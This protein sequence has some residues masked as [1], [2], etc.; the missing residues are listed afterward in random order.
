M[1]GTIMSDSL[2]NTQPVKDL[3]RKVSGLDNDSGDARLKRIVHRVVS[4]LFRTI[5]E[6]DVQPDEFWSAMSYLT[7]LGQ[8]NETGLLVPGLGL[9]T[10]LD[11][12]MDGAERKAGIEGGT[13][14]TIE[15]PLYVAGAPFSKGEARLDDGSEEGEAL[16]MDGQVRDTVGKP[17]AG[18]VVDVW[19]ANPLGGYSFFDPSQ[20][21]YNL[22]RRIETD[23]EGRYRFRSILPAGYACPPQGPTQRLLDQLGRHGR[24]PAHIHFF[25]TAPGYRKLTTQINIDGDEYLHDDFAFATRDGLI[26]EVH[27]S[28]DPAQVRARGL[29]APFAEITFDFVLHRERADAPNTVVTRA[30]AEAA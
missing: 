1:E 28:A 16:F 10:F 26:P 5:E 24:R 11:M 2:L 15:G 12:R 21:K 22:R 29:N 17:I 7:S 4:D 27:C 19:H 18:A 23:A 30:H 3:L 9:E 13:P 20:P 8:A 6:F 14:R 25:V